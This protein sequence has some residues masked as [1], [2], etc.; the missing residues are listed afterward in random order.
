[1]KHK[2]PNEWTEPQLELMQS[3]IDLDEPWESISAE[4]GHPVGSCKAKARQLKMLAVPE[5]PEPYA[6]RHPGPIRKLPDP[7]YAEAVHND[8]MKGFIKLK[9]RNDKNG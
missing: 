3:L 2:I 5:I 4:V 1:M 7:K 8:M 9:V 6:V